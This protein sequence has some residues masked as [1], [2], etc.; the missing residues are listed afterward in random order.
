MTWSEQQSSQDKPSTW[1]FTDDWFTGPL[2]TLK[3]DDAM[4][5]TDIRMSC[6]PRRL[7][8]CTMETIRQEPGLDCRPIVVPRVN[9]HEFVQYDNG[10][11]VDYS[12]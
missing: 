11:L 6:T 7:A 4:E 2:Y 5:S 12:E 9:E 3:Q 10:I 8:T 1:T